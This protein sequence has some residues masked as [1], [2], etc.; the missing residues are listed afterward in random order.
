MKR[1]E[2]YT[3]GVY[4][5]FWD[6]CDVPQY[7]GKSINIFSRVFQHGFNFDY[8]KYLETL[9]DAEILDFVESWLIWIF[10]PEL[11]IAGKGRYLRKDQKTIKGRFNYFCDINKEVIANRPKRLNLETIS[12]FVYATALQGMNR[13]A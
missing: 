5:V 11:N 8:C 2:N 10:Q 3:S 6:G 4:F 1:F 12:N 9:D 13:G 7:I